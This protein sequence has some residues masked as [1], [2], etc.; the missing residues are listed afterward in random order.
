MLASKS[1]GTRRRARVAWR[2]LQQRQILASS[3]REGETGDEGG[4][5]AL[6]YLIL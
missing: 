4:Q 2:E 1:R 5:W 6:T 3:G